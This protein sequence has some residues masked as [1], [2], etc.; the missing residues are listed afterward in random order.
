MTEK[1]AKVQS[2]IDDDRRTYRLKY[3]QTYSPRETSNLISEGVTCKKGPSNGDG[4]AFGN[5]DDTLGLN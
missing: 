3:L 5:V 1:S 2:R 4:C